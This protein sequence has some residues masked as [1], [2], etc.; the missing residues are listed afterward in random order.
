[1]RNKVIIGLGV[2][3]IFAAIALLV[4]PALIDV[5]HYRPQIEGKLR[6]RLGR[7]VSLA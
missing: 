1:M 5:N 4:A 7:E 6:D 3:V 2:L